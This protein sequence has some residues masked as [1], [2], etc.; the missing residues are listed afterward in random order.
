MSN[1]SGL[2]DVLNKWKVLLGTFNQEKALVEAFSLIV[3][4]SRRFV[5]VSSPSSESARHGGAKE[6]GKWEDDE[7]RGQGF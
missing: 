3:K 5:L 1:Y 4:S 2:L 7:S 6:R